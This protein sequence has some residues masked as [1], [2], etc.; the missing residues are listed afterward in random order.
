VRPA[1]VLEDEH[2]REGR[3]G[4]QHAEAAG[5]GMSRASTSSYSISPRWAFHGPEAVLCEQRARGA[6]VPQCRR[7]E[8]RHTIGASPL[9][10]Q[11]REGGTDAHPLKLVDNLDGELRDVLPISVAHVPSGADDRTV[12]LVDGGDCLVLAMIDI[13]EVGELARTQLGLG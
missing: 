2:D 5:A 1:V 7:G 8:E 4:H 6:V 9:D 10:R 3:G 11:V 13:G 12:T